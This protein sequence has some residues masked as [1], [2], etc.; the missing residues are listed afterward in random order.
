M[1]AKR[2]CDI[3]NSHCESHDMISSGNNMIS[4]QRCS[5][6]ALHWCCSSTGGGNVFHMQGGGR[7]LQKQGAA[8]IGPFQIYCDK[9]T[10]KFNKSCFTFRKCANSGRGWFSTGVRINHNVSQYHFRRFYLDDK[11]FDNNDDTYNSNF[12]P[13]S[14]KL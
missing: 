10:D 11:S 4:R 12:Y 6:A 1:M 5:F 14:T 7:G 3:L 9:M 2:D 8:I 13:L